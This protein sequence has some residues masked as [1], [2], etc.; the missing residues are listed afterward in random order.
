[1]IAFKFGI[2][3][4]EDVAPHFGEDAGQ[5]NAAR[6]TTGND[7][8]QVRRTCVFVD[9]ARFFQLTQDGVAD[10]QRVAEGFHGVGILLDFAVAEIV[11]LTAEGDDE[12][13]VFNAAALFEKNVARVAVHAGDGALA[14]AHARV[15]VEEFAE[16]VADV[17]RRHKASGDLVYER[18]EEVVVIF[19]DEGDAVSGVA[20]KIAGNVHAGEAA[21]DDDNFFHAVLVGLIGG[22]RIIGRCDASVLFLHQA[23]RR[24]W[25]IISM[26]AG[27]M[28]MTMMAARTRVRFCLTTGC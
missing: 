10:G 4:A 24:R 11:G 27:R 20:A 2:V 23:A 9:A 3:F 22:A 5:L 17:R 8:V 14:E 25:R 7:K 1:M 13:V 12:G 15:A 28:E 6:A 19:V 18:R 21:A 26:M 16:G